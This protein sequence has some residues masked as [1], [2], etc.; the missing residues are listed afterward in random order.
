MKNITYDEIVE[1][2]TYDDGELY[3][4]EDLSPRARRGQKVGSMNGNGYKTIKYNDKQFKYHRV[5]YCYFN[6]CDYDD[7]SGWDVDHLD[8]DK[9]NN[10]IENLLLCEHWENQLNRIDT[11]KNGGVTMRRD[12]NGKR[13]WTSYGLQL[14]RERRKVKIYQVKQSKLKNNE[15]D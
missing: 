9:N 7:I 2:F 15:E 13:T 6:E 3:Y 14:V 12:E 11:K 10:R 8:N 4:R 1:R 5:I